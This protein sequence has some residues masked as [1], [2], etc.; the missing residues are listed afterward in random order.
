MF[1]Y[2]SAQGAVLKGTAPYIVGL[3]VTLKELSMVLHHLKG[4]KKKRAAD[5]TV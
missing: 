3:G 4:E 1:R 5:P 2:A